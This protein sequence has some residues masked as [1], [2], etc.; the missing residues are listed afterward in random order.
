[1]TPEPQNKT[2]PPTQDQKNLTNTED[3]KSDQKAAE[4][5]STMKVNYL[6]DLN[7]NSTPKEQ[8]TTETKEKNCA[9]AFSYEDQISKPHIQFAQHNHCIKPQIENEH[10]QTDSNY[11]NQPHDSGIFIC[12]QLNTARAVR[13]VGGFYISI[14]VGETTPMTMLIDTGADACLIS[15]GLFEQIP[16]YESIPIDTTQQ[17]KLQDFSGNP[18]ARPNYATHPRS[19]PFTFGGQTIVHPVYV[20]QTKRDIFILGNCLMRDAQLSLIHNLDGKM[21][22]YVGPVLA[23]YEIIQCHTNPEDVSP[24][25]K[26]DSDRT[27]RNIFTLSIAEAE[28]NDDACPLCHAISCVGCIEYEEE[29]YP[30]DYFIPVTTQDGTT[31]S[32]LLDTAIEQCVISKRLIEFLDTRSHIP[33]LQRNMRPELPVPDISSFPYSNRGV[34]GTQEQ[35]EKPPQQGAP[36]LLTL[37]IGACTYTHPFYV[38]DSPRFNHLGKYNLI[39]GNSL[40]RH[41]YMSI[42][43]TSVWIKDE[44]NQLEGIPLLSAPCDIFHTDA[45]APTDLILWPGEE[46]VFTYPKAFTTQQGSCYDYKVVNHPKVQQPWLVTDLSVKR[47]QCY[48]NNFM[49]IKFSIKLLTSDRMEI[50]KGMILADIAISTERTTW[51]LP[52]ADEME[53]VR[54][55]TFEWSKLNMTDP[56]PLLRINQVIQ[57]NHDFLNLEEGT[58]SDMDVPQGLPLPDPTNTEFAS[59]SLEEA[60]GKL[61]FPEDSEV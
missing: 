59:F 23:P 52:R 49:N 55:M 54:N 45:E 48:E 10:C 56:P 19:I 3:K 9:Q 30:Y 6:H 31:L 61:D 35:G 4:T 22:I 17:A 46:L 53:M 1:M 16:G 15:Q 41:A 20:T 57:S 51:L 13:P 40:I 37:H 58:M 7:L 50:P 39:A 38:F 18:I 28:E 47:D 33:V 24:P 8:Q 29:P 5:L 2:D 12:S 34:G 60:I 32:M 14:L 21:E 36:R 27:I 25:S 42:L 44:R 43:P 11:E 26:T